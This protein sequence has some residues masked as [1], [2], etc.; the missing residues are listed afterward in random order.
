LRLKNVCFF[1]ERTFPEIQELSK[2][3]KSVVIFP[4]GSIEQHGPHLPLGTDT[5]I[6]EKVLEKA[7]SKS[8]H[9]E[10]LLILPSL[11]YGFSHLHK[12]FPGTVSIDSRLLVDLLSTVGRWILNSGFRKLIFISWHGANYCAM[13][14]ASYIL[15]TEFPKSYIAY[16]S[17]IEAI[18]NEIV[19]MLTPPIYH[20]DDLE[21]SI[22]LAIGGR[23]IIEELRKL[24][25]KGRLGNQSSDLVALDFRKKSKIKMPVLIEDYSPEGVVGDL[26]KVDPE[27]GAKIIEIASTILANLLDK[28]VDLKVEAY[29]G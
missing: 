7:C 22:M 24:K 19:E 21:T 12:N 1:Q 23:V 3:P 4:L 11:P 9:P 18:L 26:S 16:I 8:N 2:D 25:E 20:A 27:K 13:H 28:I 5:I 15:K 6:L 10:N 17:L 29:E 14:D